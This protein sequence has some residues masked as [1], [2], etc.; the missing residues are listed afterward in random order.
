MS[1]GTALTTYQAL[2]IEK[3]SQWKKVPGPPAASWCPGIPW[4][5]RQ[6]FRTA[7][8]AD[9]L[10]RKPV[11]WE[12]STRPGVWDCIVEY[13]EIAICLNT[14]SET[15]STALIPAYAL[16]TWYFIC[17]YHAQIIKASKYT[18]DDKNTKNS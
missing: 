9:P 12:Q 10:W 4:P 6:V 5:Q 2:S 16:N 17:Q 13:T 3:S 15:R 8:V 1:C 14:F 18:W 7:E 11:L